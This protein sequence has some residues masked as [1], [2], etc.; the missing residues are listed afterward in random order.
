MKRT[1][2]IILVSTL[3]VCN[4]VPQLCLA[5]NGL[6]NAGDGILQMVLTI[7]AIYTVICLMLIIGNV[8]WKR[9][10]VRFLSIIMLVPQ[11]LFL[12]LCF[13]LA[14]HKADPVFGLFLLGCEIYL[15]T[16]SVKKYEK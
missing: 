13:A 5:N 11:L 4:L 2:I 1:S 12:L 3:V 14:E 7:A 10:G 9:F 15:I 16:L 8:Y 6:K